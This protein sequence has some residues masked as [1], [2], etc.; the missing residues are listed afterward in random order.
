[1]KT[2]FATVSEKLRVEMDQLEQAWQAAA[3]KAPA[4]TAP[5]ADASATDASDA[6]C[7]DVRKLTDV[8]SAGLSALSVVQ[9][10]AR[11]DTI[12]LTPVDATPEA[13]LQVARLNRRD[14]MNARA[15][16]VDQWRQIEIAANDLESDLDVTFS[17][18]ISTTDNNPVRFRGTTGRLRVGLEF[19]APLTRLA[20][21]NAYRATLIAYQRARR[22]FYAYEDR[23]AE[24]LR[25][26]IRQ[27]RLN[28]LNFEVQRA[29]VFVA[30]ARVDQSQE[31]LRVPPKVVG[32]MKLGGTTAR[33][34]VDALSALLSAQN[35]FLN[36][37]VSQ[38]VLRLNLDF[39]LGTM[40][41]DQN[42]MWIDPGPIGPEYLRSFG[43]CETPTPGVAED[44]PLPPIQLEEIPAPA[45]EPIPPQPLPAEPSEAMIA[46]PS[47]ADEP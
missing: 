13:A 21:R 20:E 22:D 6:A 23:V 11:L 31:E 37:W 18:D 4:A 32:T 47:P 27:I 5:G 28:Q 3:P 25:E 35:S 39:D 44:A 41:L 30:I 14:W 38:E 16:L 36:V 29:A 17:G 9:A 19:D 12:T 34:L 43:A 24:G 45:G 1:M 10:R 8:L 2:D 40:Q 15:A 46:P 42:G 26:T 33:D 7:A